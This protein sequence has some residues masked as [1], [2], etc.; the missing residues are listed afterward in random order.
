LRRAPLKWFVSPAAV[1][2]ASAWFERR[3]AAVI[4]IS[5]FVPGMRL[6]TYF[7]SG[8]LNT[9]FWRFSF[10]FFVACLIWTPLLVSASMLFGG[11]LIK[12]LVVDEGYVLLRLA[13]VIVILYGVIKLVIAMASN[14]GR[15]LM[16]SK[17]KRLTH[18]EFWPRWAFYPPLFLY[19]LFLALRYR[20][21]TLFTLANPAMPVGGFIGE[22][23]SAILDGLLA[24]GAVARYVMIKGSLASEARLSKV[25]EFI[26][27]EGLTLPVVLKPDVGQR[28][29]GVVIA[30]TEEQ[31]AE[32]LSTI[33]GDLI[34]QEFIAGEEYGVFYY[35]FRRRKKGDIFAITDKRFPTVTGDGS[36]TLEDLILHDRRA[37][38]MARFF[39]QQESARLHTVPR[40]EEVIKLVELGT[41]CRG[42]IFLDGT[43]K[44]TPSLT[45]AIEVISRSYDGFCF[46]RYDIR[47]PS[48]ADLSEGRNL[49]VIELNGV[50]S[51]ATSIYDPNNSLRRAYQVLFSQ[52]RIAFEIGAQHRAMGL[53]PATIRGL[54][55][56]IRDYR[57]RQ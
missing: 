41:H 45:T 12:L 13:L 8:V 33:R 42:A 30:K 15:R 27:R 43:S 29:D 56:A 3:G 1:E 36:Q 54:L 28:G 23:K 4:L 37:I 2:Q 22:S 51:E 9:S 35:G 49:K 18:W 40:A 20:S 25:R 6:P 11:E 24:S 21:L 16:L 34:V 47:V 46:G 44:I 39:L 31:L 32:T 14:R 10:Y 7:A 52:W 5:R 48:A 50:T 55:N 57:N 26:V 38:S 53:K 17:W 19:I